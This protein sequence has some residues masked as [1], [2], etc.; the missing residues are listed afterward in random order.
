MPNQ[1]TKDED[2]RSLF[3]LFLEGRSF[4]LWPLFYLPLLTSLSSSFSAVPL[5]IFVLRRL[6][7]LINLSVRLFFSFSLSISLSLSVSLSVSVYFC[8]SLSVSVSQS[9]SRRD[10]FVAIVLYI[11]CEFKFMAM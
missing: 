2:E 6:S 7:T 8:L 3:C 1:E 10:Y 4:C 9:L 5:P 11:Y